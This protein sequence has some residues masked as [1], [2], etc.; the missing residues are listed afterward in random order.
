[1]TNS[2]SPEARDFD[3]EEE[4]QAHLGKLDEEARAEGL[5]AE[6]VAATPKRGVEDVQRD[7]AAVREEIEQL[8]ARLLVI[9]QQAETAV[10]SRLQWADASAHEQLGAYPW[11]KLAGAMSGTFLTVQAV[12]RLPL[13]SVVTAG[14]PLVIAAFSRRFDR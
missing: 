10:T 1:M 13:G 14:L 12:K 3:T 6:N 2:I 11:L 5:F 8:R 7:I 9:R 4:L